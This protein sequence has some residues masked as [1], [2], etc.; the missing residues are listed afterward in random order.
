M[1]PWLWGER[2]EEHD[3]EM[4][5]DPVLPSYPGA[6]LSPPS[7]PPPP[8]TRITLNAVDAQQDSNA[9]YRDY[10]FSHPELAVKDDGRFTC[11]KG[12]E[13]HLH[14]N[15]SWACDPSLGNGNLFQ[16]MDNVDPLAHIRQQTSNIFYPFRDEEEYE[17]G[18][19]LE[20]SG[21]AN[22]ERVFKLKAVRKLSIHCPVASSINSRS[23][24]LI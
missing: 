20:S 9:E 21:Q 23:N 4:H 17:L 16:R 13:R 6:N 11:P 22:I 10:L 2:E 8:F 1:R 12:A 14:P 3:P 18:S 7:V 19:W 5:P 15:A 24:A